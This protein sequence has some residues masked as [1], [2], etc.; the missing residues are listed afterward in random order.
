MK[1]LIPMIFQRWPTEIDLPTVRTWPRGRVFIAAVLFVVCALALAG[2]A[3]RM[4]SDATVKYCGPFTI[5]QSAVGGC[6]RIGDY[7]RKRLALLRELRND[8]AGGGI[9][10]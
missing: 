9:D 4:R 5:G 2:V 3:K 6:D 1:N 8:P 7:A 10:Q